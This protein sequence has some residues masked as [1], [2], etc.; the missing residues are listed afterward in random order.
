M[1]FIAEVALLLGIFVGLMVT[2]LGLGLVATSGVPAW[3]MAR[4]GVAIIWLSVSRLH[5]FLRAK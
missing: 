5:A 1:R 3:V 2:W 4:I